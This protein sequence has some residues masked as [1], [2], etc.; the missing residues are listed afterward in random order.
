[1]A[2]L[3]ET[4]PPTTPLMA[5]YFGL[6]DAIDN[7]GRQLVGFYVCGIEH[8]DPK[9][10]DTLC[11]PSWQPKGR[12]LSSIALNELKRAELS[13]SGE[14]REFLGYAG[15]LGVALIVSRFATETLVPGAVRVVGFDSGDRVEFSV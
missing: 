3:F 14:T 6:Y 15:Q 10:H 8:Y 7:D 13:A 5:L 9:N 4:Q 12:Y 2:A 1:M 11:R